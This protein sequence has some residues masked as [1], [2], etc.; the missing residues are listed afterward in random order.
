MKRIGL[1]TLGVLAGLLLAPPSAHAFTTSINVPLNPPSPASGSYTVVLTS[2][3]NQNFTITAFG[4]NDGNGSSGDPCGL[5]ALHSAGTISLTFFDGALGY[6]TPVT[7]SGGST[8]GAGFT[9]AG[10]MTVLGDNL[11]FLSPNVGNDLAPYGGN[12]FDGR[13]TLS[14]ARAR[15]VDIAMQDGS[16]QWV[17]PGIGLAP[18][19]G[20]LSLAFCGILPLGLLALR[21]M[22][23]TRSA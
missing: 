11:R 19:P 5:P 3:D 7:A 4:N 16:Q 14:S 23:R 9:V 2:A 15:T 18:E 13:F 8:T 10:W 17:A 12:Q 20:S 21:K 22:G 6:V 1:L